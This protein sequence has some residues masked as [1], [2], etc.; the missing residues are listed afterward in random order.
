MPPPV[1]PLL[2]DEGAVRPDTMLALADP[3]VLR[4]PP[5][6]LVGGVVYAGGNG[7]HALDRWKDP[8]CRLTNMSWNWGTDGAPRRN[9]EPLHQS[10]PTGDAPGR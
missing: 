8:R 9:P 4:L 7:I 5:A 3:L 1:P 10:E 6:L 2:V